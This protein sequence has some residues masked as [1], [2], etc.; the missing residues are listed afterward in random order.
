MLENLFKKMGLFQKSFSQGRFEKLRMS[1]T[2]HSTLILTS[3]LLTLERKKMFVSSRKWFCTL[4][5][6]RTSW[7]AWV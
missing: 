6:Q 7:M 5:G 1:V 2:S 4:R 3:G